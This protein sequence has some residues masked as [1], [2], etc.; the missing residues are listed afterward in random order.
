MNNLPSLSESALRIG[1]DPEDATNWGAT[2]LPSAPAHRLHTFVP[3][4]NEGLEEMYACGKK[5]IGHWLKTAEGK[6]F[7]AKL[8]A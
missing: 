1:L 6:Q 4:S 5:D 3:A 2:L 7:Q 8:L